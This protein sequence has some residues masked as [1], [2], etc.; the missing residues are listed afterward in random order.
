MLHEKSDEIID[1]EQ[2]LEQL[3]EGPL[4]EREA[5]FEE[6]CKVFATAE[7]DY[8]IAYA[9]AFLKA[10]GT[11]KARHS[12]ATIEV[13][14]FLR[15]RDRAEAVKEFTREK[16]KDCQITISARQSLLYADVQTNKTLG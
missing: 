12:T 10:E 7:S 16:L 8:R 9:E 4:P 5:A 14:K 2:R 6:S 15:E 13:E 11:E 3:L 1:R